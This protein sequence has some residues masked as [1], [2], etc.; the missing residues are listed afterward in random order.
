MA[1]DATKHVE[2]AT[3]LFVP[4]SRPDSRIR[5]SARGTQAFVQALLEPTPVNQSLRETV[6]RYREATGA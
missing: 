6:Q 5:F 3:H 2:P 1:E 4:T